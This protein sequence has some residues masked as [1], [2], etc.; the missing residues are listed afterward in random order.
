M[1]MGEEG[2]F[3]K[4]G[5]L[6]PHAPISLQKLFVEIGLYFCIGI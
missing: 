1:I 5:T 2:A 4:K 3:L 6:F